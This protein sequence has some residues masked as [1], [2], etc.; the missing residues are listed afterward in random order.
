MSWAL[1]LRWLWLPKTE[2]SKP[3]AGLN[4]NISTKARALF[5]A[6]VTTSIGNGATTLFWEDK[7]IQELGR[8]G[9]DRPPGIILRRDPNMV[10]TEKTL[11][12]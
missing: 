5:Q 11:E 4:L 12:P 10:P 3:W 9:K 2:P 7:W 6:A 8:G 1:Q